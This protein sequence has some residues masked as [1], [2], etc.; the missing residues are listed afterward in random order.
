VATS[1]VV[2][3][4][5]VDVIVL[6][7]LTP[8]VTFVVVATL[9]MKALTLRIRHSIA[10]YELPTGPAVQGATIPSMTL[11]KG[12]IL[13]YLKVVAQDVGMASLEI[14]RWLL[15]VRLGHREPD[16]RGDVA[17]VTA[18]GPQVEGPSALTAAGRLLHVVD[19]TTLAKR[20]GS[21]LLHPAVHRDALDADLDAV[22]LADVVGVAALAPGSEVEVM[23][24]VAKDAHVRHALPDSQVGEDD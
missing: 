15:H 7:W 11:Q 5:V 23:A 12:E 22:L 19:H 20:L 14:D 13:Y 9:S 24:I 4:I 18:P 10:P 8:D 3:P 21:H 17:R 2:V 16:L 6:A 1:T